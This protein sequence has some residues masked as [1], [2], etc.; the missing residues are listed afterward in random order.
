M[1]PKNKHKMVHNLV[2]TEPDCS[3]H[4]CYLV[5]QTIKYTS[6]QGMMKELAKT[7]WYILCYVY[8]AEMFIKHFRKKLID[9]SNNEIWLSLE[10]RKW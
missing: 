9:V 1:G 7:N 10:D 4:K 3:K 2:P 5:K 6:K 8:F